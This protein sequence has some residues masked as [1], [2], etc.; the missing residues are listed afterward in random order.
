MVE[1][2]KSSTKPSR[3]IHRGITLSHGGRSLGFVLILPC[4]FGEYLIP[5]YVFPY[6]SLAE[7]LS[8]FIKS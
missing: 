3:S 6:G 1:F 5:C 2:F 8:I 7:V 4:W